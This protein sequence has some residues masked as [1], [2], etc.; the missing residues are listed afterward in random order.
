MYP[1]INKKYYTEGLTYVIQEASKN[2]SGVSML[3]QMNSIYGMA[4]QSLTQLAGQR[5]VN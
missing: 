1:G 2:F 4:N 3:Q 5:R